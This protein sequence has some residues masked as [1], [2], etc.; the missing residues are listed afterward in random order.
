[1]ATGCLSSANTPT[2]DG[3]DGF[4]GE[5]AHT[6]R[7]PRDGIDFR[8]KRVGVVGTGSSGVQAIPVIAEQAAE[9]VVFQRTPNYSIPARNGPLDLELER[10]TK[11]HY[12]FPYGDFRKVHRCGV[13]SLESRAGQFDHDEIRDEA[14]KLLEL[15]DE[16]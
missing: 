9:L 10:E 1:M 14:K 15:I 4:V 5:I 13:I 8:G 3:M 7:W 2:I 6:G 11:A 16:D 12:K